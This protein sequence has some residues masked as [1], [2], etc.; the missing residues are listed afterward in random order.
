LK[1]EIYILKGDGTMRSNDFL[2]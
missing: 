1:L 2:K